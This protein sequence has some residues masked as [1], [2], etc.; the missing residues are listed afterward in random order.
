MA[1]VVFLRSPQEGL[2]WAAGCMLLILPTHG[3]AIRQHPEIYSLDER[4]E[5][6]LNMNSLKTHTHG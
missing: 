1:Y 2:L 4:E 6:A 5:I 3:R